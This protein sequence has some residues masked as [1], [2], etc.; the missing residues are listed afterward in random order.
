MSIHPRITFVHA[1][2]VLYDQNYGTYF[3]P[4]WVYTL[5]A[6]VPP[7]WEIA[8]HDCVLQGLSGVPPAD[9]FA[10]SGINQDID[11][12]K[13]AFEA[14]KAENPEAI[15]IVGGP[16]T[17]SLHEEGKLEA[18]DYFDYRFLLDGEQT[19]PE[20]L[21]AVARGEE[22]DF[23]ANVVPA[24][25]FALQGA[26]PIHFGLITPQIGKYYGAVIEVSRGCPFLCEFCDIRVLPGNNRS[27][28]KPVSVVM[29][30]LDAY[31]RLGISQ[32]QFACDNFIGDKRWANDLV[33]AILAWKERTG[34]SISIFTWLSIDL[35]SM[36]R[37]MQRMR[38]AGFSILF[39]GIESVNH[40]SLLEAAKI[41][42]T[43][44]LHDAVRII[45]SYGFIIVPGFVFGFDSDTETIFDDTLDFIAENGLIGGDP[46]FLMALP[47]TPLYR[48]MSVS[49]RLVN[50]DQVTI[51]KKIETNITYLHD[52]D[53]MV[54]G[55][56]SFLQKL[57]SA[58]FQYQRLVRH[59]EIITRSQ[60]LVQLD[61]I[62]YGSP[63]KYLLLQKRSLK[64]MKMLLFRM[65]Y[66][67]RKP[68]NAV[69]VVKGWWKVRCLSRRIKG[70]DIHFRYWLYAWTNIGLKYYKLSKDDFLLSSIDKDF[71]VRSYLRDALRDKPLSDGQAEGNKKMAMQS[72]YTRHA[73]EILYKG[74]KGSHGK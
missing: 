66:I 21:L 69:A 54:D 49:G 63:I 37:L 68:E 51:R 61:D 56:I 74:K 67:F 7:D 41:Q 48:R 8:F 38:Q 10:F 55:F 4:L 52:S 16:I 65:Y 13:M 32:Y 58:N 73:L 40:N 5:A 3:A 26:K 22:A 72:R 64:N 70:L 71:D 43:K 47:G 1:P 46:S 29:Q 24:T 2:V 44:A 35:Y 12:L 33:D 17:W 53:F 30:E 9:V 39:I 57:T 34:A 59:L 31:Y 11:S 62:G 19:L 60:N 6:H 20:F 36:P 14:I 50:R 27:S 15:F 45:Q 18:L 28:G 25:R 42:N 23:P